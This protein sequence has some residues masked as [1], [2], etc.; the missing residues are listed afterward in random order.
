M[1]GA[2]M[3]EL[4]SFGRWLQQRR[5]SL[6][7]T[8]AELGQRVGVVADTI[9]KIEADARRPSKEVA[10]RLAEALDPALQHSPPFL[11]AARAERAI[12]HLPSARGQVTPRPMPGLL[13]SPRSAAS[14]LLPIGTLTLLF[15]DIE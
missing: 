7:L 3:D 5:Q 11:K 4:S 9:R 15:T 10:E 2:M 6:D 14:S 13:S 1:L 8:Q 12:E